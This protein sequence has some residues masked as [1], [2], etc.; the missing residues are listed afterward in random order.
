M[1]SDQLQ[2]IAATLEEGYG[3]CPHGRAALMSWI[4]EEVSKLKAR[5]VPGGEAATIELGLAY[6]AW[7]GEE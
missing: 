3:D 5:G 6:W 2:C 1:N 7:L 4:E